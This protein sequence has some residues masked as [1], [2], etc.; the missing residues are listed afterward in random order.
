MNLI[1]DKYDSPIASELQMQ[2]G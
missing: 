1:S 2:Q